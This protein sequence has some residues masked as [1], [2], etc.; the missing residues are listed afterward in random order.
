MTEEIENG[1]D[2]SHSRCGELDVRFC[3]CPLWRGCCGAY[4]SMTRAGP[5]ALKP[6]CSTVTVSAAAASPTCPAA[7]R[8]AV[9]F[10]AAGYFQRLVKLTTR[11]DRRAFRF[12]LF[13][14]RRP[15]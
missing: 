2:E 5:T 1:S 10:H 3:P 9:R 4:Y 15:K 12:A 6:G 8:R 11:D 7:L 13:G 14:G